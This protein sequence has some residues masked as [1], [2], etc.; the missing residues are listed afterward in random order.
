MTIRYLASAPLGLA[1]TFSLLYAMHMLIDTG[2]DVI[3]P[4]EPKLPPIWLSKHTEETVETE[5]PPPLHEFQHVETPKQ[6]A[7]T[8]AIT[9]LTVAVPFHAPQPPSLNGTGLRRN[10]VLV[11]GPLMQTVAA[12]AQY[13]A[14]AISRN[15]EGW[16]TV[17][18][19]VSAQGKPENVTVAESTHK[20]LESAAVKAA[21]RFRFKP[22]V[23]DGTALP[24]QALSYRFI[25]EL[26]QRQ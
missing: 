20:I 25:F 12:Q 21:H 26:D 24:S 15:I 19:D 17:R 9:G 8:D 7:P 13:P 16:V 5:P 1:I 22:R 23:V 18:F 3:V 10:T 6:I 14:R 4:H 11:D 2:N